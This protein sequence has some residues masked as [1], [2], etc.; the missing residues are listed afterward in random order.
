MGK[1]RR[2]RREWIV[3]L[4]EMSKSGLTQTQWCQQNNI[5]YKTMRA[6]KDK[7]KKISASDI[8]ATNTADKTK[9]PVPDFV[10]VVAHKDVTVPRSGLPPVELRMGALSITIVCTP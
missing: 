5:N 9:P 3:L 4:N 1:N 7:I 8:G 2:S 6:M 10:R